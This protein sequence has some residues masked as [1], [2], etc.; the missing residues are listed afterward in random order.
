M[1]TTPGPFPELLPP[2]AVWK[3]GAW[4][5]D[6]Q[7]FDYA[8]L[9]IEFLA[10]HLPGARHVD[11]TLVWA[12]VDGVA[13]MVPPP[14]RLG[15][16][17]GAEGFDP[18]RPALVYDG[19]NALYASR[20]AWALALAGWPRVVLLEGGLTAWKKAGFPVQLG[21]GPKAEATEVKV[22]WRVDLYATLDEVKNRDADTVLLDTRTPEEFLG[23][24]R[25][26]HRAGRIPGAVPWEWKKALT[27]DGLTFRSASDL[28]ADFATL[29]IGPETRVI[30]YCQSGV[31]AAHA[32]FALR[33]AGVTQ[34]RNYDGSWEEWGNRPDT[35]LVT[36]EPS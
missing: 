13:G 10:G 6:F 31:R 8:R 7:V 20:L 14:A 27:P 23:K 12:P 36:G 22:N 4:T 35:P 18:G 34:S 24:D 2:E 33:R 1:T 25:R 11:K 19:G 28:A 9:G 15:P 29:G 5:E 21:G 17:L 26:S 3:D 32:L 16:A 30:T